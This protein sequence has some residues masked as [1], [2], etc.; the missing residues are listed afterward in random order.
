MA[1]KPKAERAAEKPAR[2]VVELPADLHRKL[3]GKCG[4]NGLK[5]KDVI[6]ELLQEWVKA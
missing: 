3:K 5:I 4:M 2:L 6:T 1:A